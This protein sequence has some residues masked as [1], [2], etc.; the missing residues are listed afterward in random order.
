MVSRWGLAGWENLLFQHYDVMY[1]ESYDWW[2]LAMAFAASD[3]LQ[4][5]L[6]EHEFKGG[7]GQSGIEVLE[8]Y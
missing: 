7:D 6:P 3:E 4:Q 5:E 2:I 1:S 8:R